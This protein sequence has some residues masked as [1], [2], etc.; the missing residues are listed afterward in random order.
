MN[1]CMECPYWKRDSGTAFLLD[2]KSWQ[3]S[4]R[5]IDHASLVEFSPDALWLATAWGSEV[6]IRESPVMSSS[7]PQWLPELAEVI[8]GQR[9]S[10]GHDSLPVPAASFLKLK[11][12]IVS[13][14]ANDV[15]THWAKWLITITARDARTTFPSAPA[16]MP[17]YI[18]Q[19]IQENTLDSLEQAVRLSPTNGL[20]F[21]RLAQ[22]VLAKSEKANPLRV[23][24]ADFFSR[25]ARKLAPQDVEVA[26]IRAEV[27]SR[28]AG[29]EQ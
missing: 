18:Q 16:T 11:S 17:A 28:L 14:E 20:A 10:E 9:F 27:A 8:V 21:A 5:G 19:L 22:Q 2:T 24:E 23:G 13:T 15:Y 25:H 29:S 3:L 1:I 12:Q 4:G 26:R 7:A 6:H